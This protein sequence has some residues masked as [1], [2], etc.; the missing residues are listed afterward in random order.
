MN[1]SF[2]H[3][4]V[5]S[6]PTLNLSPSSHIHSYLTAVQT[7]SL[8]CS[9]SLTTTLLTTHCLPI[10]ERVTAQFMFVQCLYMC[11]LLTSVFYV[12]L[13]TDVSIHKTPFLYKII[14]ALSLAGCANSNLKLKKTIMQEYK[15]E[16]KKTLNIMN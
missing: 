5:I 12:Y 11:F 10:C 3:L 6:S 9:V 1:W 7:L 8:G 14:P 2:H 4:I 15:K 16:Q 13:A